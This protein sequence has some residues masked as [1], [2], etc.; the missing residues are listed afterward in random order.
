VGSI[1]AERTREVVEDE[2]VD[3]KKLSV[4]QAISISAFFSITSHS[5]C[6]A[7]I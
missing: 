7:L 1:A 6:V 5:S 3:Q 2:K 4:G